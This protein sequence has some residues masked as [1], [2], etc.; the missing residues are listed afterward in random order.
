MFWLINIIDDVTAAIFIE[1]NEGTVMATILIRFSSKFD[2]QTP[3][4]NVRFKFENQRSTSLTS[5]Q[6]GRLKNVKTGSDVNPKSKY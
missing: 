3:W 1:K 4:Q 2:L 5:G 6:K